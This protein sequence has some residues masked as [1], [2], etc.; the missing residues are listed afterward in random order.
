MKGRLL[1]SGAMYWTP[2]IINSL[3]PTNRTAGASYYYHCI[4]HCGIV[5]VLIHHRKPGWMTHSRFSLQADLCLMYQKTGVVWLQVQLP[6]FCRPFRT[7]GPH[8]PHS[9]TA[10]MP[11]GQVFTAL[12]GFRRDKSRCLLSSDCL[13]LPMGAEAL[14]SECRRHV[15]AFACASSRCASGF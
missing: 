4:A 9:R 7:A 8:L 10:N 2:L 12:P 11:S 3:V 14:C 15:L 13:F 1:C 5:S 6:H